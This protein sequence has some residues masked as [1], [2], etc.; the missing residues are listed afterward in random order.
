RAGPVFEHIH[1]PLVERFR[2]PHMIRH[3]IE[4]L[5]HRVRVQ[6]R[7]PGV[8]FLTR[9]NH[10]VEFVMVGDVVA[11]QALGACLKMGRRVSIGHTQGMQIR[12]DLTCLSEREP[13]IE[14]QSVGRTGNARMLFFCYMSFQ[15]ESPAVSGLLFAFSERCAKK[16]ARSFDSAAPLGM[17]RFKSKRVTFFP[18]LLSREDR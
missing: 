7:S 4:H 17:T 16:T 18:A 9:T 3:E 2:D 5:A 12:Y 8:V 10:G 1:P 6:F 13:A 15:A 14:L 11:V